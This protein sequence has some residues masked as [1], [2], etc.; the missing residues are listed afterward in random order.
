M[1]ILFSV[2]NGPK[3]SFIQSVFLYMF[4]MTTPLLL[5]YKHLYFLHS[6]LAEVSAPNGVQ[7]SDIINYIK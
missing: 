2:P 4:S 6:G 7:G 5:S 1:K 3:H